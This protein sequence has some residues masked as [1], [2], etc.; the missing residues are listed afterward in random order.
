M[1]TS[2]ELAAWLVVLL[3]YMHAN[4]AQ[5]SAAGVISPAA[6]TFACNNTAAQL[7]GHT[8][9]CVITTR[10]ANGEPSFSK[11]T[12]ISVV[13]DPAVSIAGM[14]IPT[15]TDP[16]TVYVISRQVGVCCLKPCAHD[17]PK[18]LLHLDA[19]LLSHASNEC[20]RW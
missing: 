3:A 17:R 10:D 12:Q 16:V 7:A 5:I 2:I 14:V 13:G 18:L 19:L 9:Q 6:S 8:L 15:D 11:D 1:R 20:F 4:S